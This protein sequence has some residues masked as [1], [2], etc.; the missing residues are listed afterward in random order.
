MAAGIFIDGAVRDSP[1]IKTMAMPVFARSATGPPS[2]LTP[3]DANIPINCD[4]AVVM[5]GDIIIRDDDGVCI[6]PRARAEELAA[7][8]REYEELEVWL[9]YRLA[10]G[11]S[12]VG[13]YPPPDAVRQQY[14]DLLKR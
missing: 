2:T 7:M 13:I 3:V 1:F 5:P 10:P 14:R 8:S 4:G 6:V 12:I 11:E 9:R